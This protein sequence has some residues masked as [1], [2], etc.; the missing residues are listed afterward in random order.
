M[1]GVHVIQ[2]T[3]NSS[4]RNIIKATSVLVLPSYATYRSNTTPGIHGAFPE[5]IHGFYAGN[6]GFDAGLMYKDGE[7]KLFFGG[8]AGTGDTIW[9][10]KPVPLNSAALGKTVTFNTQF[11][12]S[13]KNVMIQT[14]IGSY[15]TSLLVGLT[16]GAYNTMTNGC[17]FVREMV[18]AINKESD[19]SILVP[20]GTYFTTSTFKDT[21][22]VTASGANKKL[23][24]SISSVVTGTFDTGTPTGTYSGSGSSTIVNDYVH[25]TGYG[26]I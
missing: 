21:D 1:A 17:K 5:F 20:T 12:T 3:T 6:Y 4:N 15:S 7:F 11:T 14:S 13:T 25:D 2:R 22:L 8:F 9:M 26:S 19:G 16:D 23:T 24:T 18:I 10:D